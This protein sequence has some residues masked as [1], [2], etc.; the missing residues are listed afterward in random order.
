[1]AKKLQLQNIMKLINS[2]KGLREDMVA[3]DGGSFEREGREITLSSFA[4]SKYQVT[5]KLYQELMNENPAV[6][7]GD[8]RPV[9]NVS[10][11][12]AIKFCNNLSKREGLAVAYDLDTGQL[13]DAQGNQMD[14]ITQ[15]IGYRLPTE[16]EWEF[17][18]RGGNKSKGYKYAGS[19]NL[20]EVGWYYDNEGRETRVVGQKKSNELGL[21]GM[22]GNVY[23]WCQDWYD[24]DA[25]AKVSSS[26]PYMADKGSSRVLRG[27]SWN[28]D[29]KGCRVAFRFNYSPSH[30]SYHVG[31]R[32][33]RLL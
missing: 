25:Y 32:P 9:E 33:T 24:E 19:N 1:M 13:V 2:S 12:D 30:G 16:A 20:D 18:A 28:Y 3:V 17:A 10:W 4:I 26:N 14:D 15:V 7:S 21:Y 23:E 6:F 11:W 29:A 27:G 5:Q 8:N 31:F 22:S